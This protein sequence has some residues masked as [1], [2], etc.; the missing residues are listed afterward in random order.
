MPRTQSL[1]IA[2]LAAWCA[3]AF[4]VRAQASD[5]LK[6]TTECMLQVL[7]VVPGVSEPHLGSASSGGWTH[8]FLEYRADEES[9]W[10]QPTRFDAQQSNNGAVYF[11]AV[12]PGVGRID[13]HVTNLVVQ[14]WK[15]QCG[16]EA[17]VVFA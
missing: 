11:R 2:F 8:P 14:K 9:H 5:H 12:L 17:V 16:V 1:A 13:T 10:E 6:Q 7:R 3:I 4:P 15:E